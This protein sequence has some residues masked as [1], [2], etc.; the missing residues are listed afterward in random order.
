[1]PSQSGL[2]SSIYTYCI[3]AM[4]ETSLLMKRTRSLSGQKALHVYLFVELLHA[5][6]DELIKVRSSLA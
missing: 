4:K 2:L 6:L 3:P 1:M 5:A